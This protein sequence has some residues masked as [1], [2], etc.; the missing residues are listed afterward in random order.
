FI[1]L[2]PKDNERWRNDEP[3]RKT[4]W[5]PTLKRL[6]IRRRNPYETRHTYATMLLM[7]GATPAWSAKQLGHAVEVFCRKYARWIDGPAN[8]FEINKVERLLIQARADSSL[9]LP[10]V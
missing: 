6:G 4:Y 8:A 10:Q 9:I 1:F 5:N 2:D 7:A 3:P